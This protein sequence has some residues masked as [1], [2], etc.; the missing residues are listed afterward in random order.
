MHIRWH[1]ALRACARDCN[2][3]GV[4]QF[5][6]CTPLGPLAWAQA[7]TA[8]T[9]ATVGS[10]LAPGAIERYRQIRDRLFNES[11][12]ALPAAVAAGV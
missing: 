4:S 2:A 11:A 6:G 12:P 8:A 5:F 9:T 1:G 3:P 10:V 7:M